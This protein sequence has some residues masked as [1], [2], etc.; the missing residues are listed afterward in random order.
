MGEL[1][2]HAWC[3][4]INVILNDNRH[5]NNTYCSIYKYYTKGAKFNFSVETFKEEVIN[6]EKQGTDFHRSQDCGYHYGK[7]TDMT[8]KEAYEELVS[9]GQAVL[10]FF[11]A[12]VVV[13]QVF[14][15]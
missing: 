12:R 8:E 14:I 11:L 3:H 10:N 7:A 1:Q 2:P 6:G 15:L 4:H 13:T 5:K 9:G